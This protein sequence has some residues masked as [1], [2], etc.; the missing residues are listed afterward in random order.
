MRWEFGRSRVLS[1]FFGERFN[2]GADFDRMLS[3]EFR[4]R[5]VPLSVVLA[6]LYPLLAVCHPIFVPDPAISNLLMLSAA[7]SSMVCVGV[8]V[9][10]SWRRPKNHWV[11]ALGLLLTL[12]MLGNSGLHQA[13]TREAIQSTN[14][15]LV[16]VG[17]SFV[18]DYFRYWF[19]AVSVA[20]L[21]WLGCG[22]LAFES[23]ECER[24]TTQPS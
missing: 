2:L 15:L 11:H 8:A 20:L 22:P 10:V 12:L 21:T 24:A 4:E 7:S 1:W 13:L 19:A 6:G 5:L 16:I 23:L 18:F 14:F 9:Y 3:F 17:L